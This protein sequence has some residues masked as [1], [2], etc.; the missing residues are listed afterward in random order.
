M[1]LESMNKV[2]IMNRAIDTLANV[3][4]DIHALAYLLSAMATDS[5]EEGDPG[6]N[7]LYALSDMAHK[8]RLQAAEI[9]ELIKA[10]K[11]L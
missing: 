10:T 4:R 11:D 8:N 6:Y 5:F 3:Q 7:A 9:E 1:D 2:Q